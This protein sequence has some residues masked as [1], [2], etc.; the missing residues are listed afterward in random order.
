MSFRGTT[1]IRQAKLGALNLWRVTEIT[2]QSSAVTGSPVPV[3]SHLVGHPGDEN[4]EFLRQI[5]QATF[6]RGFQ[7]WF[8]AIDQSFSVLF[9]ADLLLLKGVFSV[10]LLERYSAPQATNYTSKDA[11]GKD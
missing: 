10:V 4:Q 5:I 2:E 1:S 9:T 7:W 11:S 6:G 8:P 3:Y